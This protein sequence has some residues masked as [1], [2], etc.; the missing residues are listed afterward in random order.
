VGP[1]NEAAAAP[2]WA[3][4][5]EAAAAAP[6]SGVKIERPTAGDGTRTPASR[7]RRRAWCALPAPLLASSPAFLTAADTGDSSGGGGGSGAA[8][9]AAAAA[10]AASAAC[11]GDAAAPPSAAQSEVDV[12]GPSPRAA[13][14]SEAEGGAAAAVSAAAVPP[15][16]SA[17]R[18]VVESVAV[19]ISA[20]AAS[21][22]AACGLRLRKNF[23]T[24]ENMPAGGGGGR[25]PPTN[26][27]R[28][29]R[30]HL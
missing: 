13:S 24:A 21:L 29:A 5:A 1:N 3:A 30:W 7:A 20:F 14:M 27:S 11:A 26:P 18:V 17:E 23:P 15:C 8:V 19:V 4:E 2:C 25:W 28:P 12:P 9:A 10:A 22:P 6:A 16:C